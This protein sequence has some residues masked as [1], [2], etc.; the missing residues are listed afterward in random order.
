MFRAVDPRVGFDVVVGISVKNMIKALAM[1]AGLCSISAWGGQGVVFECPPSKLSQVALEAKSALGAAGVPESSWRMQPSAGR[2]SF[3]LVDEDPSTLNLVDK[4]SLQRERL[5]LGP[6]VGFRDTAP[7][8]EIFMAMMAR[9][10]VRVYSGEFCAWNAWKDEVELRQKVVAWASDLS[11]EWPDGGSAKWNEEHWNRG[12]PV[13]GIVG[14]AAALRD[15]FENE[16][17]K[18]YGVGCYSATKMVYAHA[19]IDHYK[20]KSTKRFAWALASLASDGEPLVDVEPGRLWSFEDDFDQAELS[21][22]GKAMEAI[23]G[24]APKNF[25]PGDWAYMLNTD[26]ATYAK[27][28]Y[29]GSNAIYLGA[30]RFDDYYND[31]S[32]S[33]AYE[34]KL[35][36]VWQ[37]RNGVFSRVRDADKAKPLSP[38]DFERLGLSPEQGG[39]VLRWRAFPKLIP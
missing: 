36:E 28:G 3:E 5:D 11:W 29:E 16:N 19:F 30:G 23:D 33:Y 8:S 17:Q 1:A 14:V 15:A 26:K 2:L 24:V 35:N 37:W 12:T 10:R 9:G 21:R 31:H 18:L 25:V 34:E 38:E 20:S 13:L 6:K 4:W 39:L 7:K 22:D 27:T 32:H